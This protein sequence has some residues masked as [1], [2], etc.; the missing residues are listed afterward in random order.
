MKKEGIQFTAIFT[1]ME[2]KWT[3]IAI[4]EYLFNGYRSSI[5]FF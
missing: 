1:W 3:E 5:L 2:W 4:F